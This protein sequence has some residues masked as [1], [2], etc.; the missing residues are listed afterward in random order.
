MDNTPHVITRKDMRPLRTAAYVTAWYRGFDDIS[1]LVLCVKHQLTAD[2][3]SEERYTIELPSCGQGKFTTC[4]ASNGFAQ[5]PEWQAI[6]WS[7]K[8]GD[9]ISLRWQPDNNNQHMRGVGFH[10][11]ECWLAVSRGKHR[12][13]FLIDSQV[14]PH[15]TARMCR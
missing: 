12:F 3:V 14:G 5:Y 10:A 13:M 11:D 1:E 15:N 2:Y 6:A 8:V 9:E 4:R 7:L